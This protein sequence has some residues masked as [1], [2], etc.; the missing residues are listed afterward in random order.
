M[1]HCF[2]VQQCLT[3][4]IITDALRSGKGDRLA[5]MTRLMVMALDKDDDGLVAAWDHQL[6]ILSGSA[7][8]KNHSSSALSQ[9]V[10]QLG[11]RWDYL[12]CVKRGERWDYLMSMRDSYRITLP[13]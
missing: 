10:M 13:E 2:G 11:K 12:R 5:V 9:I 3:L 8:R 1:F 7:A 4:A 6:A